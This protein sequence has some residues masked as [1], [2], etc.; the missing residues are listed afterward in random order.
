MHVCIRGRWRARRETTLTLVMDLSAI[1]CVFVLA[2]SGTRYAGTYIS[3]KT[4][5]YSVCFVVL[6]VNIKT[7]TQ[8]PKTLMSNSIVPLTF[9]QNLS[10]LSVLCGSLCQNKKTASK[11][12]KALI[13]IVR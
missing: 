10:V 1:W 12:L 13:G 2:S 11:S 8:S 6:C 9:P 4:S 7:A 5:V 3:L